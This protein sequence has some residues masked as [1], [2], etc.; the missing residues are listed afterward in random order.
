[1]SWL[2]KSNPPDPEIH[3]HGGSASAVKDD[4][5]L[6]FRGVANFLAPPP[7]SSASSS[8]GDSSSSPPSQALTGIRNDLEEISGSFKNSLSL[9][10]SNRAVTGISKLASQLLQLEPD[11]KRQGDDDGDGDAVPGTTEEVVRFVK[12]ISTRP[13]CWTEFPLPFHHD[14]SMSNSQREHALVIEQLVPEFVALRVN[15]CSYMNVEKFWMIYFL[16]ILPRLNQH[17]FELLST[18][19]IVEARDVLL[20]KLEEKKDSEA[21]VCEKQRTASDTNEDGRDGILRETISS[22]PSEIVT[23]FTNAEKVLEVDEISSTT[24][25]WLEDKDIDVTSLASSHTKLHHEEDVSF[26]D[27]DDDKSYS[28]DRISG[29]REAQD[30]RGSSPD[31]SSDWVQLHEGS[32]RGG[33]WHKAIHSKGKDSEDESNDWLTVDEFN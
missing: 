20:L 17:D 28:S 11:H 14:F 12:E 6:I 22:E 31:G 30:R 5:S 29:H 10:S 9:L 21:G 27:L 7:S 25:N 24:E 23:E 1:M 18:P 3:S 32:S 19:K 13:D 33:G 16:L 2:F 4:I 15:L 26:S 8:A